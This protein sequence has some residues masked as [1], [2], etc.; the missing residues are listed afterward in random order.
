MTASYL[1]SGLLVVLVTTFSGCSTMDKLMFW[2]SSGSSKPAEATDPVLSTENVKSSSVQELELKNAKLWTRVDELEDK[3]SKQRE[4]L[5]ILEKGLMLGILPDELKGTGEASEGTSNKSKVKS[6]PH[7]NEVSKAK[8]ASNHGDASA[9]TLLQEELDEAE[10][11]SESDSEEAATVAKHKSSDAKTTAS[12]A[13]EAADSDSGHSDSA[14]LTKLTPKEQEEYQK[15]LG[16]AHD[17]YRAGRYG[18]AVVEFSEVGKVFGDLVDGGMH[19]YWIARS[20]IGLKEFQ[21]A[22]QQLTD[23]LRDFPA[24]PWAPR[25]KLELARTE[26]QLGFKEKS[27][28]RLRDVIQSHPYE[29]AAEMAKMELANLQKNL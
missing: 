9:A 18:K 7:A 28:Q 19:R 20:W 16:S 22:R 5:K 1:K 14:A 29:D 25:A 3:V 26:F 23:F 2:K 27:L 21:T 12:K 17:H 8:K 10:E 15:L 24:S 11:D 6:K 4:R 13:V